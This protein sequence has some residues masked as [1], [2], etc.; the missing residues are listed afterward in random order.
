MAIHDFSVGSSRRGSLG[1]GAYG[2]VYRATHRRTGERVAVKEISLGVTQKGVMIT[3]E[4]V[5]H[6]IRL[7]Q[8]TD[9][10]SIVR[11]LASF[12][13][14]LPTRFFIVMELAR[15]DLFHHVRRCGTLSERS[16]SH[17]LAQ[18]LSAVEYL[19]GLGIAHRDLK[20]ENVLLFD[21]PDERM[22]CKLCDFGLSHLYPTDAR[23]VVVRDQLQHF[24]GHHEPRPRARAPIPARSTRTTPPRSRVDSPRPRTGSRS[25]QAPEVFARAYDGFESDCWSIGV[26]AFCMLAG[27]APCTVL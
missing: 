18:V 7:L 2:K 20:L 17:L 10:P 12:E 8:M 4:T 3:R 13:E 14:A 11:L 25:Y 23:G 21:G 27:E 16:S 15:D 9:H 26:C 24:V 5:E 6:E 1:L 22:P 19:H